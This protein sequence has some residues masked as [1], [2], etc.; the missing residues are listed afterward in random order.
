MAQVEFPAA[1]LIV[2][3]SLEP[4]TPE[5]VHSLAATGETQTLTLGGG[6]WQGTIGF[7]PRDPKNNDAERFFAEMSS[8]SNHCELPL[9]RPTLSAAAPVAI[10]AA[11]AGVYTLASNPAGLAPGAYVR[12]GNRV[13][14]VITA[15]GGSTPLVTLWPYRGL[16]TADT[17]G[18][19]DTIRVRSRGFQALTRAGRDQYGPYQMQWIE[20][21]G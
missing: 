14:S 17:V 15:T 2:E 3:M 18:A 5:I 4:V 13:Y 11:A 8:Q 7:L 9:S 1:A 6:Y 10:T 20:S 16:T 19:A 21:A 12:A